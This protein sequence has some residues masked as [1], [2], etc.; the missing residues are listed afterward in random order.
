M[1]K[2]LCKWEG[3]IELKGTSTSNFPEHISMFV[4]CSLRVPLPLEVILKSAPLSL[5]CMFAHDDLF[6][7]RQ[8]LQKLR[9]F[10]VNP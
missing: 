10:T 4:V 8:D 7:L 9:P 3:V 1:M 5:A 6:I 2:E